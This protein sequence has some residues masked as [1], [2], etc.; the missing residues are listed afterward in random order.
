MMKVTLLKKKGKKET[1]NRITL[2]ET[3]RIIREGDYIDLVH[4]L[5][6]VYN[7]VHPR[8]M[9]DGRM[10]TAIRYNTQLPHLCFSTELVHKGN[11]QQQRAYNGLVVLEANN[12]ESYGEAVRLRNEAGRMPQTL[13][14]FLGASGENRLPR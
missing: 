12:L 11:T 6:G 8:R 1:I 4:D 2:D 3:V 7:Y 13:M 10:E 14:T 9:A 5:R